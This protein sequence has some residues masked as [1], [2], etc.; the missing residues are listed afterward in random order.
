MSCW[1]PLL[2]GAADRWTGQGYLLAD[3]YAEG[4]EVTSG[5]GFS[6]TERMPAGTM[7]CRFAG[8]REFRHTLTAVL[9]GLIDRGFVLG[10]PRG[11]ARKWACA[12]RNL[13]TFLFDLAAVASHLGAE[14]RPDLLT[15]ARLSR[16]IIALRRR[17]TS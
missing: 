5:D 14:K 2:Q 15:R 16:R 17:R 11:V 7:R 12:A 6:R 10:R 4:A 1:N 9:N 8:P 3:D 13:G